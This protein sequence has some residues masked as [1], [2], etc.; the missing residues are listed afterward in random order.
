L[1]KKV[2]LL[3][4]IVSPLLSYSQ[5]APKKEYIIT[6]CQIA[7]KIDGVLDDI[8]WKELKVA[9][10]FIQMDPNNGKIERKGLETE[11]KIC[12]D[13]TAI[14]FGVMM[15]DHSPDSI[16]KE[17]SK[18]DEE[19]KNFDAFGIWIDPYNN[20]Q[21]SYNFLVS[22]AGVQTDAK[23]ST[24]SIDTKWDAVW[25]SAVKITDKGWVA[26]FAI[27][28]SAIRFPSGKENV[29]NIK[30]NLNMARGIRR[31]REHYTWN[32]IDVS[33]D[34]YALQNG[35]LEFPNFNIKSPVRLSVMPYAATYIDMYDG[36][37]TFPYNFGMDLKYGLNEKFTLD[38]TLI[39]DFGQVASD[40][41]ILN[42][43]PFEI[44]YSEKR[45]FF[46]EGT[47]LFNKGEEMFYTRRIQ[48]DL[49]N[50]TKIS[51]RTENGLGI[52]VLN[53]ITNKT[54]DNPFTNY[55]IMVFDQAFGNNSSV[56]FIN[57]NMTQ[58]GGEEHS[59]VSGLIAML[60]NKKSTFSLNGVLKM[61][62]VF[63]DNT[64][65]NGIHSAFQLNNTKGRFRYSVHSQ[66]ID[67]KYN[68]N[69]LGF[70][71]QNNLINNG[72]RLS[73]QQFKPS[74]HFVSTNFSTSVNYQTLYNPN[75]FSELDMGYSARVTLK[76]YLTISLM[77]SAN[78]I[79]NKD[80]YE[81]RTN[82]FT[83]PFIKSKRIG[84]Y[85]Y[86]SSDYRKDFA[87]DIGTGFSVEPL[88][89]SSEFSWRISPQYRI[90]DK[91]SMRYVLSVR[92]SYNDAGFVT[93][94]PSVILISPPEM[95]YIFAIRNVDMIT[96]V[97]KGSYVLNNKMDMSVKLRH[98]WSSVENTEYKN[99]DENGY[100]TDNN[101][102]TENK[103]INYNIW[104]VD[105]AYNWWFA[106]GSQMSIVWKN[107]MDDYSDIPQSI[108]TENISTTFSG[109]AQNSFS[110][111]IV[112]YLDYLYLRKK[113]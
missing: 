87:I 34:N 85:A 28:F 9:N 84:G 98:Y 39:P 111:K 77:G 38:M 89:N 82:N 92:N 46:T 27:P 24:T 59:N 109:L 90:N 51:G 76:N 49:L 93:N 15:Y 41:Q 91:V 99:L 65:T 66:L 60:N 96:N 71:T 108:W 88:Y 11:V 86:I 1:I 62:S 64:T 52:G 12:Y 8:L 95:D 33:Y 21:L 69:D 7:P 72:L 31:N 22:A 101:Y 102:Y 97:L 4:L 67:D 57:T 19:G 5:F 68:P 6:K 30:W 37:S 48:D 53:A 113:Q 35:L 42:L 26:E 36:E 50:A 74:K 83:T 63:E 80:F 106:P 23:Y 107:A 40:D 81:A 79:E 58:F 43:S 10:N 104:T 3:L 29:D 14:Y 110:F 75:K 100:L 25:K 32:F 44:R 17:L 94:N 47:E 54:E 70:L 73:Y 105:F 112:Y 56:G 45:Q 16:L 61:S 55:N 13:N 78:P 18:R 103:D 20:G 2:I